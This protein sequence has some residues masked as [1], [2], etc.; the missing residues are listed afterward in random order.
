ME[1]P[2]MCNR[3]MQ[4]AQWLSLNN[5]IQASM[6]VPCEK[7]CGASYPPQDV[8]QVKPDTWAAAV[9]HPAAAAPVV[10]LAAAAAGHHHDGQV[11]SHHC[12]AEPGGVSSTRWKERDRQPS[13]ADWSEMIKL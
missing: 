3:S 2:G 5:S 4:R 6:S 13:P 8:T 1:Q 10:I 9:D 11:H 7:S 12:T